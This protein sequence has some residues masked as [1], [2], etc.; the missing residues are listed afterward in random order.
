MSEQSFEPQLVEVNDRL[1]AAELGV[2]L[3]QKDNRLYVEG[4]F[5]PQ[6]DSEKTEPHQQ[7]IALHLEAVPANLQEAEAKAKA[8]G[9]ALIAEEFDWKNYSEQPS[10]APRQRTVREWLEILESSTSEADPSA[11][12]GELTVRSYYKP[13]WRR[14]PQTEVLTFA[15]LK[16]AIERTKPKSMNRYRMCLSYCK[17]GQFA[18]LD[19]EP[20]KAIKRDSLSR[21]L[22]AESLPTDERIALA[23][24]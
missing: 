3:T 11:S 10:K 16:Q 22:T 14:L 4:L 24:C 21:K 20:I 18:G 17:L 23:A 12:K 5:P 2:A 19:I 13:Y 1:E 15:L 9:L 6:P 7:Q 8:I